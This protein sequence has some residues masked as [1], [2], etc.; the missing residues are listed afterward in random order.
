[1][2]AGC[3]HGA[4]LCTSEHCPGRKFYPL[5]GP[6]NPRPQLAGLKERKTTV[7]LHHIGLLTT[8]VMALAT[9]WR[10]AIVWHALHVSEHQR[11]TRRRSPP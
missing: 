10:A 8:V 7:A 1:M 3:E 11:I 2:A 5:D 6:Q 4:T 9:G